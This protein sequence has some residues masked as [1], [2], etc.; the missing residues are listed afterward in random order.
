MPLIVLLGLVVG[1]AFPKQFLFLQAV[2]PFSMAFMTFTNSLNGGF[3]DMGRVLTRPMPVIATFVLLHLIMPSLM[4]VL[5][6]IL[7][8]GRP[9]FATGL[10]LLC[11]VPTA[12][13]S[14][15]WV[16]LGGGNTQLS[17]CLVLLDTL[18]APFLIP[19]VLRLFLG[20]TVEMDT[21]GMMR[22]LLFMVA[23]P[24]LAAIILHDLSEGRITQAIHPVLNPFTKVGLFI[25]IVANATGCASYIRHPD[26]DLFIVIA[27]V[28]GM[29]SLGFFMGYLIGRLL[30]R[31]FPTIFTMSINNGM[32]NNALGATLA[33]HYFPSD[34]MFPAALAPI[35]SQFSASIASKILFRSR[36]YRESTGPV[37]EQR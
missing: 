37:G 28:L 1:I 9:L 20:S 33:V 14:L 4:L 31:D 17:L 10:V 8:A 21:W 19:A 26:R 18:A 6:R 23:L 25:N 35:V 11:C 7:L 12:I 15:M 13:S 32:R 30:H 24:A 29:F 27:L 34:V 5:G 16:A 3:R 36:A 2:M 22:D